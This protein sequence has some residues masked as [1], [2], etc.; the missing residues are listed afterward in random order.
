MPAAPA[1]ACWRE[2]TRYRRERMASPRR[3]AARARKRLSWDS[4]R[5]LSPPG[6]AFACGVS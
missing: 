1:S 6:T 5:P 3:A 2:D 4:V